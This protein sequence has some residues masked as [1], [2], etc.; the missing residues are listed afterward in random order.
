MCTC[1]AAGQAAGT[2]AALCVDAKMTPA[3][4]GADPERVFALQ[5]A[6]LRDDQTILGIANQDPRDL[7]RQ[8]SV[9]ASA[10]ARGSRP[11][12][13]ISGMTLDAKNENKH[14]WLAPIAAKPWIRLDW[15]EPQNVSQVRITFDSGC[16]GLT[17]T[18]RMPRIQKMVRGPQPS[19][20]R[21]YTLTAVLADGSE[22]L[23]A[24]VKGNFKKLVVH[25]FKPVRA[26]AFRLDLSAT[27]G[28]EMAI[29]KE[30]RAEA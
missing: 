18:S 20:V 13:V 15:T 14:R 2:A 27:N 24:D 29:V 30:I 28:D 3:R 23:L 7:A 16:L 25:E 5:Q 22:R 10:S 21:D 8:A 1:A 11:E 6:L 26:R 12:N 9:S 17:Q 19:V 4:F